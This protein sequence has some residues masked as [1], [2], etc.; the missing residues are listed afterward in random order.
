MSMLFSR[1]SEGNRIQ[2][3]NIRISDVPVFQP[4]RDAQ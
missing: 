4:E 2:K 3:S 1:P